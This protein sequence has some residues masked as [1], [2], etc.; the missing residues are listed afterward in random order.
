VVEIKRFRELFIVRHRPLRAIIKAGIII[1]MMSYA[2]LELFNTE[3]FS[4]AVPDRL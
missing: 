1:R 4:V 2:P 3:F